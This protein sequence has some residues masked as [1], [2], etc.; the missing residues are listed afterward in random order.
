MSDPLASAIVR[1]REAG[2]AGPRL[3][4]RLLWEFAHKS[5]LPPE[6]GSE[7][8]FESLIVRRAAREPLAYLVGAKEF[9]SLDF[10]VGPGVLIPRP[11]SETL[12][13]ELLR[14]HPGRA[15][16]LAILD[17]GTG[18][19]CLLVAA[20]TEY[21]N[22]RGVGIDSSAEALAYARANIAA[23][24]LQDRATLIESGWLD[25]AEP[26]FD[27]VLSNPPYIPTAE[28]D[29][30]EPDVARYEP[31]AA[32]DGGPDGLDAYRALAVRIG[33]LLKPAGHAFLE[34]GQGQAGAVTGLMAAQ[35]LQ[36]P[37]IGVDLAGIPRCAVV[38][39]QNRPM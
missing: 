20:L 5:D 7:A 34:L 3:D 6:G 19:G 18:S 23:H 22:A 11:D 32:L 37:E 10:A 15:E 30:L 25:G 14:R 8:L 36:T 26:G 21:P 31:R 2:I 12:I 16:P 13:G 39:R 17:L 35:G 9:W 28:I 24:G 29:G 27:V 38:K 4:A 33:S 1:L